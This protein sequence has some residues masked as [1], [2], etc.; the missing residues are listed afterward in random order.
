MSIRG[1]T[2]DRSAVLRRRVLKL[3]EQRAQLQQLRQRIQAT[4]ERLAGSE[5]AKVSVLLGEQTALIGVV[6]PSLGAFGS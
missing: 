3:A 2:S 4:E 1:Q 5:A 6:A